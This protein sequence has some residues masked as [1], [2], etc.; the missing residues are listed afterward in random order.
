MSTNTLRASDSGKA[1]TSRTVPLVRDVKTLLSDV[2]TFVPFKFSG[3]NLVESTKSGN[4]WC[5]V[6]N[7][8]G[9]PLPGNPT[10]R[11]PG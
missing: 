2:L 8:I 3:F 4:I 5:I 11:I 10:F 1:T 9:E 6:W 7:K